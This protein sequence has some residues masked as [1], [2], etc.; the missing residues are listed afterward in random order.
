VQQYSLSLLTKSELRYGEMEFE[1][2][3]N[4]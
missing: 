2:G 3:A 1:G 4:I